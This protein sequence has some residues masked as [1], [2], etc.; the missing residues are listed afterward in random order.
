MTTQTPEA[1]FTG[2]TNWVLVIAWSPD[3]KKLA[4]GGADNKVILW[5]PDEPG[6]TGTVLTAHTKHVVGL[7]W[8]PLHKY[9]GRPNRGRGLCFRGG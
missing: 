3:G 1:T 6:Q 8:E 4:S 2:H 5:N 7:S 9:A